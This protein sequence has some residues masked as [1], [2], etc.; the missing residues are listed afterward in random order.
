MKTKYRGWQLVEDVT[1]GMTG[2]GAYQTWRYVGTFWSR[3]D[4]EISPQ[5]WV[6]PF[7][8]SAQNTGS[9][10]LSKAALA[11]IANGCVDYLLSDEDD[12]AT[13]VFVDSDGCWEQV[14]WEVG[15]YPD[16]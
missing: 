14:R 7:R 1:A 5:F 13:T 11:V 15:D 9:R 8:Q 10:E 3:P 12:R 2:L 4:F 6:K 16:L